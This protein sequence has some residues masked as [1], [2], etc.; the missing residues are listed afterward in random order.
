MLDVLNEF[1]KL[2]NMASTRAV[3][4]IGIDFSTNINTTSFPNMERVLAFLAADFFI[5]TNTILCNLN[6]L[7]A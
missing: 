7:V 1:D 2:M 5:R 6:T 3:L 4:V